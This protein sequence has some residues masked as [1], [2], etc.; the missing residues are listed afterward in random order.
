ME[1]ATTIFKRLSRRLP[2]EVF[3]SSF[4]L[5]KTYSRLFPLKAK[6]HPD[7]IYG[8]SVR[9]KQQMYYYS[10]INLNKLNKLKRGNNAEI[11]KTW[12]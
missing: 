10:I 4:T 11:I 8:L 5:L 7:T 3:K 6:D 12:F 2:G 1:V 9:S